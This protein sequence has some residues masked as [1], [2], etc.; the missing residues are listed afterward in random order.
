M[1]QVEAV[2]VKLGQGRRRHDDAR[3]QAAKLDEVQGAQDGLAEGCR[4]AVV[5]RGVHGQQVDL[6]RGLGHGDG[7]A[8]VAFTCRDGHRVE[9]RLGG[10]GR[11]CGCHCFLGGWQNQIITWWGCSDGSQPILVMVSRGCCCCR[12][13]W[14]AVG[15]VQ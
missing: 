1:G 6:G 7:A 4:L 2:G 3:R 10:W 11:G 5:G 15:A 12:L 13:V 8:R 9:Q 14:M